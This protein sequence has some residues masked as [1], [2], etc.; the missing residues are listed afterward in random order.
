MSGLNVAFSDEDC[1]R[2]FYLGYSPERVNPGDKSKKIEKYCEGDIGFMP[3]A[4]VFVDELG[5]GY[6]SRNIFCRKYKSC[7]SS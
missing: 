4:A 1:A 3:K 6:F 2:C 5:N 7:R